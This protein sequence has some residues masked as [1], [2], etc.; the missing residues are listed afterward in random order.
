MKKL[1]SCLM[2]FLLMSATLGKAEIVNI[3]VVDFQFNPSSVNVVV[4]DIVRFNFT[5]GFHNA[6]SEGAGIP[7]G[8]AEINSGDPASNVRSYDYTVSLP[9]TYNY[10]C[11][12]HG[13]PGSGM[14]G[15]FTASGP[16][17]VTLKSFL[18]TQSFNNKPV[19]AWNTVTEQN[20]AYFSLRSSTDGRHFYE[21]ANLKARANNL[22]REQQYQYT[23][24]GVSTK[25][26]YVYYELV[27]IDIN[28]SESHSAIK[29]FKTVFGSAT[30]VM[31]LSPNPVT[32]P[33]QLMV[34]FNAE[35][36]GSMI[37][38][39]FDVNGRRV[40]KTNLAAMPGLN[41]GHMHVCDLPPGIY[42]LQFNYEGIRE[43]KKLVVN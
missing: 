32:K 30:L 22:N 10:Y 5:Q 39:V 24:E 12:V 37:V 38:N 35:R 33:S 41:N 15:T 23:D 28:G 26:R 1:L 4:G 34:Q 7:N 13:S 42:T 11:L 31:Q 9:G 14:F 20:V 6:T 29:M 40:L 25:H 19:I 8:A 36:Q 27:I 16:L 17:P 18:V 21:I 43:M 2:L 3:S